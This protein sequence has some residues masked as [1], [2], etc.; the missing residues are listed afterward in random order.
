MQKT[1]TTNDLG[2]KEL[3]AA[4]PRTTEVRVETNR[5]EISYKGFEIKPERNNSVDYLKGKILRQIG[6][7]NPRNYDNSKTTSSEEYQELND[8]LFSDLNKISSTIDEF[9]QQFIPDVDSRWRS[10]DVS[11]EN[12]TKKLIFESVELLSEFDK[13]KERGSRKIQVGFE[14]SDTLFYLVKLIDT[15][16]PNIFYGVSEKLDVNYLSQLDT[17]ESIAE[18]IKENSEKL[19]KETKET[20][21]GT[22]VETVVLLLKLAAKRDISIEEAWKGKMAYNDEREKNATTSI[23]RAR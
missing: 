20:E 22:V 4:R 14:I 3:P 7:F 21:S 13:E 23:K 10:D 12:I 8:R 9:V 1:S 5:G 11:H 17:D 18:R 2:S 15:E 16:K 19:K 6:S